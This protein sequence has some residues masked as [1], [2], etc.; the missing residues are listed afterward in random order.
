MSPSFCQN[1]IVIRQ[2]NYYRTNV[3]MRF[4]IKNCKQVLLY[5]KADCDR[6]AWTSVKFTSKSDVRSVAY[7]IVRHVS[8]LLSREKPSGWFLSLILTI[9][10]VQNYRTVLKRSVAYWHDGVVVPVL[11][12]V[13]NFSYSVRKLLCDFTYFYKSSAVLFSKLVC[14]LPGSSRLCGWS[15]CFS[16]GIY[17]QVRYKLQ[18]ELICRLLLVFSPFVDHKPLRFDPGSLHHSCLPF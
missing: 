17:L 4:L 9:Y 10:G 16:Y 1:T 5:A 6:K 12:L 8:G 7:V 15:S 13:S 14:S 18:H 3:F 2:L 11:W